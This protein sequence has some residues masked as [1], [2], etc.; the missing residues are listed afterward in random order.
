MKKSKLLIYTLL[1]GLVASCSKPEALP[2]LGPKTVNELGDTNYFTIPSYEFVNHEGEI[3]T[4]ESLKGTI[5][6]AEFFFTS[7]PS[8]CPVMAKQLIRVHEKF[9]HDST[10]KIVSFTLDPEYDT[11]ERL[12]DHAL[13][14]DIDLDRW[15]FLNGTKQ[16]TYELAQKGFFVTAIED[17]TQPGGVVHSGRVALIDKQGRLRGYYDATKEE[18]VNVLINDLAI[19]RNESN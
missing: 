8:I 12:K 14:Q 4:S 16:K 17:N 11:P 18:E 5:Y 13:R 6:V 15:V 19:L 7:C 10:I 3:T 1:I 9:A 2:F